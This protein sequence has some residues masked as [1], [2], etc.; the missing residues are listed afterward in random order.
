MIFAAFGVDAAA[1]CLALAVIATGDG[2]AVDDLHQPAGLADEVGA[3]LDR[4]AVG[5]GAGADGRSRSSL[6]D[7]AGTLLTR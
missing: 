6:V 5:G 3:F 7:V 1:A 4:G 2:R